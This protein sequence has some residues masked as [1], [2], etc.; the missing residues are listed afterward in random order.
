MVSAED[1]KGYEWESVK[2]V[3]QKGHHIQK[4]HFQPG[5]PESNPRMSA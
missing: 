4:E 2:S 5:W 3:L 1:W